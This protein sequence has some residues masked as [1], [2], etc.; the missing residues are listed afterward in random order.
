MGKA[1]HEVNEINDVKSDDT[2]KGSESPSS[3][4]K[5][6]VNSPDAPDLNAHLVSRRT[7]S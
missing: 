6:R 2:M 3:G 4:S 7:N 5:K 1:L